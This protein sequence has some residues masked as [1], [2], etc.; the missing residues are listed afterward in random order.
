MRAL[1]VSAV[2]P[3]ADV[4]ISDI[5]GLGGGGRGLGGMHWLFVFLTG[6]VW[7]TWMNR[8]VSLPAE[9]THVRC[10]AVNTDDSD[11]WFSSNWCYRRH[12]VTMNY[13]SDHPFNRCYLAVAMN[14]GRL[15]SYSW[16][17]P[18]LIV[19]WPR[20]GRVLARCLT[21]AERSDASPTLCRC[22]VRFTGVLRSQSIRIGDNRTDIL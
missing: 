22:Q 7:H 4:G 15:I 10:V 14:A 18:A 5:A 3:A 6:L 9:D 16:W 19:V 13:G 1:Q 20:G 21:S 8:H 12:S 2:W 17:T 11:A